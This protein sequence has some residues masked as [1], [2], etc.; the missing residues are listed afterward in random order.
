M[1]SGV[2]SP[3]ICSFSEWEIQN[4]TVSVHCF[5]ASDDE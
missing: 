5:D 2:E 4:Q 1:L 3:G